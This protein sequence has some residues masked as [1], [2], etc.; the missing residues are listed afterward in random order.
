M[1]HPDEA[2][3]IEQL[4]SRYA[5]AVD[6]RDLATA[7][8]LF[9]QDATFP[10]H[11]RGTEGAASFLRELWRTFGLSVH[12]M[13]NHIIEHRDPTSASGIVYCRAERRGLDGSW[14][15]H[16]LAYY[17]QYVFERD[18]W[19]FKSRE[20]RYWFID[21]GTQHRIVDVNHFQ[22]LPETWGTWDRFWANDACHAGS[23]DTDAH[24][25]KAGGPPSDQPAMSVGLGNLEA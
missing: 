10:G 14:A 5:L 21:D 25:T 24:A 15:T 23:A 6:S 17:D 18:S 12:S 3:Q 8:E 1:A 13:S 7:V 2:A 11:A 19:R 4:V 22:A 16:Q 20:I 9:S